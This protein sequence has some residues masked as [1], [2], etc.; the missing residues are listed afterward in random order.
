MSNQENTQENLFNNM[1]VHWNAQMAALREEHNVQLL[2]LQHNQTLLT[3]QMAQQTQELHN[4]RNLDPPQAPERGPPARSSFRCDTKLVGNFKESNK[5]VIF[6]EWRFTV[7]D[8]LQSFPEV[9]DRESVLFVSLR[10]EGPAKTWYQAQVRTLNRVFG[11]YINLLDALGIFVNS[12]KL[13]TRDRDLL[14]ALKQTSTVTDLIQRLGNIMAR[15]NITDDEAKDKFRRSLKTEI[16]LRVDSTSL[17]WPNLATLQQEALKQE[18][19]NNYQR[20]GKFPSPQ[21]HSVDPGPLGDRMDVDATEVMAAEVQRRPFKKLTEAERNFLTKNNGCFRCRK[22]NANHRAD[23]CPS[24]GQQTPGENQE[25]EAVIPAFEE[26]ELEVGDEGLE[27]EYRY[28]INNIATRP[29]PTTEDH[30]GETQA[31]VKFKQNKTLSKLSYSTSQN[32]NYPAPIHQPRDTGDWMLN[33]AI[34]KS[35]FEKWG[36]PKIDLFASSKNKQAEFYYR[37]PLSRSKPGEGCLGNDAFE[38]RWHEDELL[39]ANPPWE[40]TKQLIEKIKTQQIKR[41][42]VITPNCAK[43][44]REMSIAKPIRLVHTKDLFI[45]PS[46]QGKNELG[47]GLPHWKRTYAYLI[48]GTPKVDPIPIST[49]TD[50]RFVFNGLINKHNANILVDSG[51]TTNVISADFIERFRIP[52]TKTNGIQ[53]RFGNG[54]KAHS[55]QQVTLQLVR[56]NY[57]RSITFIVSAIKHDAIIGT[58]WF[59]EVEIY[60]LDW[61]HRCLEFYDTFSNTSHNWSNIAKP[62]N[63]P[64]LIHCNLNEIE[65]D[66]LWIASIPIQQL[67]ESEECSAIEHSGAYD[68][69]SENVRTARSLVPDEVIANLT[70]RYESVFKEPSELPPSRPEDHRIKFEPDAKMP[71]W[72]PLSCLLTTLKET[73]P[74]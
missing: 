37:N 66:A 10:L 42:I 61:R 55:T 70:R 50:S 72:R 68:M 6:E 44:L 35:L 46:Q 28:L 22:I 12:G 3:Q 71:P 38:S 11:N 1:N 53:L 32:P 57:T 43:E 33:K 18:G 7:E 67:T 13:P 15:L 60:N 49:K 8:Y 21:D 56:K 16:R 48:S 58:P 31:R 14:A 5:L 39:Y 73:M 2:A 34:A 65:R 54:D 69:V 17:E 29:H 59:A 4:I 74:V 51:C 40:L 20:A 41:I 26:V 25:I 63:L 52:T 47:V 62:K 30:G 27:G 24:R 64:N 36:Q 19:V 9:G 45:P 23:T